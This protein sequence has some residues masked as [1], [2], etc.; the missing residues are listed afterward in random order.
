MSKLIDL[1]GQRF[2][3]WTVL[4][5]GEMHP[6]GSKGKMRHFWVCQCDC[7][8]I[9]EVSGDNLRGGQSL[10]CGCAGN[11]KTI[12]RSTKHGFARR[13]KKSHIYNVWNNMLDRCTNAN[14][15]RFSY[16]G[17]RGIG[18]C[19]EWY[20]FTTFHEWAIKSGYKENLS[21]DRID[22]NGNY[23][24]DNCRWVPWEVQANNTRA[25][26]RITL[27]RITHSLADWCRAFNLNYHIV[28]S[29]R[30]R[31]WSDYDALFTP[32]TVKNREVA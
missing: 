9:R 24:P 14:N 7:G 1:T 11:E 20:D 25:N 19:S 4:R 32:L 15:E 13:G 8:T 10:C 5:L 18:V 6:V 2:G 22:V 23:E 26:I 16:Y 30:Q 3:K 12:A 17:G 27:G 31:G 21:I 28:E 29:R